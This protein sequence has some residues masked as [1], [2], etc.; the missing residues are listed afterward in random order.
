[1]IELYSEFR[2]ALLQ[3]TECIEFFTM[4]EDVDKFKS[5]E[6]IA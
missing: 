3:I 5:P 6:L 4:K 2:D 1:M